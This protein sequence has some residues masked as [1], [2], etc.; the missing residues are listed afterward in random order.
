[1]LGLVRSKS[2]TQGADP[3]AAAAR[4]G[5]LVVQAKQAVG[6]ALGCGESG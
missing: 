5:V 6:I 3:S 4:A 1:M 2:I